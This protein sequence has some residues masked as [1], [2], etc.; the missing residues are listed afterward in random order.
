MATAVLV[1]DKGEIMMDGAQLQ[2]SV[3]T[4]PEQLMDDGSAVFI[5]PNLVIPQAGGYY[6]RIDMYEMLSDP[7]IGCVFLESVYT[8]GMS[9]YES[10]VQYDKSLS[11]YPLN[12]VHFIIDSYIKGFLLFPDGN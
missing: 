3:S 4:T 2:G 10:D 6:V 11:K 5:F 7:E 12:F 1:N 8:R 9:V